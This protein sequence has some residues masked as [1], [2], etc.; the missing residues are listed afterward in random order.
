MLERNPNY[1]GPRPARLER[2]AY[3]LNT[4]AA[5][6]VQ[7]IEAGKADY[8]AD[9]LGDS[10]FKRGGPLDTQ[11]RS[12]PWRGGAPAMRYAPVIGE[13]FV[14]FNTRTARSRTSG[15]GGRSTSRSTA[16]LSRRHGEV[17]ARSTFLRPSSAGAAHLW[18][19]S[20]PTWTRPGSSPPASTAR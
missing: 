13:G 2:I 10:Q 11:V 6:A 1:H 19:R 4:L 3:D 14:Q 9:V 16:R 18:C 12:Q 15:S 20:S 5:H 7:Q 17:P 8:T